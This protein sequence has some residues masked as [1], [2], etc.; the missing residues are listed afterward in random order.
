M[1]SDTNLPDIYGEGAKVDVDTAA[2][3]TNVQVWNL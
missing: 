2:R 3:E 1:N